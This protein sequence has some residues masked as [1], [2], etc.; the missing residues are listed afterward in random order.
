M[1][2]GLEGKEGLKMTIFTGRPLWMSPNGFVDVICSIRNANFIVQ[3]DYGIYYEHRSLIDN[4]P[5]IRDYDLT[6]EDL[7]FGKVRVYF[8]FV[9]P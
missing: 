4:E 9:L 5:V 3:N 8:F 6:T 1:K 7:N 2:T